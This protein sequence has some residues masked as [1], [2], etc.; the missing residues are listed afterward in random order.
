MVVRLHVTHAVD[1]VACGEHEEA[2]HLADGTCLNVHH[3]ILT[4]GHVPNQSDADSSS[5]ASAFVPNPKQKW[6]DSIPPQATVLIAGMGLVGVDLVATLTLGRG[7]RF[8]EKAGRLTYVPS[9]REPK[10]HLL[11]RSGLPYRSKTAVATQYSERKQP[12]V[13]TKDVIDRLTARGRAAIDFRA[14]VLPLLLCEM[15][16]RYYI[17]SAFLSG[18]QQS[19]S[20]MRE[21]FQA[22]F[23]SDSFQRQVDRAAAEFGRFD[24]AAMLFGPERRYASSVDYED[25][26]C[27]SISEEL[28]QSG[29]YTTSAAHPLTAAAEAFRVLRDSIR[30]VVEY[31]RLTSSSYKDFHG[32]LRS[33]INRLVAGPP[34]WRLRQIVAL[35]ESEILRI[36]YGPAPIVRRTSGPSPAICVSSSALEQ[37]FAHRVD[38]AIR[39]YLEDPSI[40]TSKSSLVT[41]LY[42]SGRL[43]PLSYDETSVGSLDITPSA[44]PIDN[45]GVPQKRLWVFG[46]ITEG[47]RYFTH[48]I[49]SPHR[50]VRA[51]EDIASCVNEILADS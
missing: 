29:Y 25:F 23:V 38:F 8:Q 3:V 18:G 19:G 17:Q 21:R 13:F 51:F 11:S 35:R 28:E 44:H 9:G 31:G 33:R 50:G 39:G 27:S 32:D 14:H 41:R 48:Y 22:A 10:L 46:A 2:V 16:A 5:L 47:V 6:L 15:T 42:R 34:A 30:T 4:I 12:I 49:P 36:P 37:P 7:G 26:V 24:A 43:R 20:T 1:V 40:E 45:R